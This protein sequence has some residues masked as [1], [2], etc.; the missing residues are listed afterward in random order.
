MTQKP[1]SK[2]PVIPPP[3]PGGGKRRKPSDPRWL[4][5]TLA[6]AVGIGAGIGSYRLGAVGQVFD[7]WLARMIG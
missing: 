5:W 7:Y 2:A 6:L 4:V 1:I 3:P